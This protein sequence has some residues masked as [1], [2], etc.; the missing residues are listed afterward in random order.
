V[1]QAASGNFIFDVAL[2][3]AVPL[4]HPANQHWCSGF[5]SALSSMLV[6]NRDAAVSSNLQ[7][8]TEIQSRDQTI[9]AA[10]QQLEELN[11]ANA[12]LVA[13]LAAAAE[14]GQRDLSASQEQ[15]R[16][17][18]SSL[19]ESEA[20]CCTLECKLEEQIKRHEEYAGF[21]AEVCAPCKPPLPQQPSAVDSCIAGVLCQR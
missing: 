6:A 10:S 5:E 20:R 3:V 12:G 13:Q 16:Q 4:S 17:A 2:S 1:F 18:R 14:F 19:A 8:Q 15:L 21:I 9:A 7:L 11:A